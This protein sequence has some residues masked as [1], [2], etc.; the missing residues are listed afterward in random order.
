MGYPLK[1]STSPGTLGLF[2]LGI[3]R[4][5]EYRSSDQVFFILAS[6]DVF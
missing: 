5:Y 6:S 3:P 4:E 1:D 2:P